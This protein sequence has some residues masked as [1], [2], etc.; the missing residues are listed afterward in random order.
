M[1]APGVLR[2]GDEPG[3]SEFSWGKGMMPAP[4]KAPPELWQQHV[5]VFQTDPADPD[6]E[7]DYSKM[8]RE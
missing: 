5:A 6:S 3:E 7:A 1:S 8:V 2:S 4:G